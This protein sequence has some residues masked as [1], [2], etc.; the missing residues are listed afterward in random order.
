MDTK[1]K[2]IWKNEKRISILQMIGFALMTI[3]TVA[4]IVCSLLSNTQVPSIVA[5]SFFIT[6]LGYSF[7]FPSLLEG[8]AGLSTMRIVVFMMTNIICMLLLKIGW[9]N[10]VTSLKDIGLDSYWVGII[11]FVFGAKATQR[12]FES[13]LSGSDSSPAADRSTKP[14]TEIIDNKSEKYAEEDIIKA[15]IK[16]HFSQPLPGITGIGRSSDD[17]K[18]FYLQINVKDEESAKRYGG[19]LDVEMENGDKFTIQPKIIVTGTAKTSSGY[20]AGSGIT[21]AGGR[22]GIGTLACVVRSRNTGKK[23]ILSC[24]HVLN[25]DTDFTHTSTKNSI[26]DVATDTAIALHVLGE[27]TEEMDAGLAEIL[28]P[29]HFDNTNL[30]TLRGSRDI[31]LADTFE[32][33]GVRLSGY[34][35][36]KKQINTNRGIIINNDFYAK[37]EYSDGNEYG[38]N[39]LIVLSNKNNNLYKTMT[40]PG[41]SGSLVIDENDYAIGMI[42]GGDKS[43]SYAIPINK[44][45]NKFDCS[46][47]KN[48]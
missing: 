6:M 33:I 3:G 27:R 8:H 35:I 30:G 47:P 4:L 41:Y 26:M 10:T 39:D 42:V 19:T 21:N 23:Y 31:T 25:H 44:I 48:H 9:A 22:N 1:R 36:N 38:C 15:A 11:A 13:S 7:A 17:G 34:D 18:T 14:D 20:S 45:L 37:F 43:Y 40:A 16:Q 12:Y 2:L 5:V 24:Q 46:I 28:E 32:T 29:D